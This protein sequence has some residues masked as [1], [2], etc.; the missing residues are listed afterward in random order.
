MGFRPAIS[1]LFCGA[2][3]TACHDDEPTPAASARAEGTPGVVAP[4]REPE[5]LSLLDLLDTCEVSHRGLSIDLGSVAAETQ[6]SFGQAFN[7]DVTPVR[8]GGGTF[9]ELSERAVDYQFWLTDPLDALYVSV[10]VRGRRAG[11]LAVYV[12]GKRL[13]SA[14]LEQNEARVANFKLSHAELAP[15][16]H[17]LGLRL[18]RGDRG[19]EGPYAEVEWIRLTSPDAADDQY[20]APTFKDMISDVVLQKRPRRS[21]ALRDHS[22]V[23]CPIWPAADTRL[24]LWLGFWGKGSGRAEVRV[25]RQ[26]GEA[27]TLEQREIEGGDEATWTPVDLALGR[28]AGELVALEFG[29]RQATGTGRVAFGDPELLR[30][31]SASDAVNANTVVLVVMAGLRRA[32][33]PPWGSLPSLPGFGELVRVGTAFT[34]YRAPSTVPAAA[35]AS[36]LTGVSPRGHSVED[37]S[38]RLPKAVHTINEALK[39]ASGHAAMFTG[40]P[41]SFPAFGFD[42][43]WD[44][45]E[46][47]SPVSDEPAHAPFQ[48]AEAWLKRNFERVPEARRFVLI[49]SRGAHP[50]WDVT[51]EEAAQ[52]KPEEYDGPVDA[53]RG[54]IALG[55]LRASHRRASRRLGTDD[56]TRLRALELAALKKQDAAFSHLVRTL[57]QLNLWEASLVMVVGDVAAGEPPQVPYYPAGDLE[58]SR[59][60]VP[61]LVKFPER[62][63]AGK[64]VGVPVTAVDLAATILAAFGL[65]APPGAEGLDLYELA[66]GRLPLAGRPLVATLGPAFATRLG[67][68]RLSGQLGETPRL[69]ELAVDPAC[70]NNVFEERGFVASSLWKWTYLTERE[71]RLRASV[72]REPASIDPETSAA[73]AVWGDLQ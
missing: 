14:R 66:R 72:T 55:N 23:R 27:V 37:Q 34:N 56:W 53:R 41:T 63:L 13:G 21:I 15:G 54:G 4:R 70:V 17:S 9:A 52:M 5:T 59:L 65:E 62:H 46:T 31:K 22:V 47:I 18:S 36:M 45:Q 38:A 50:P 44:E 30:N 2:V 42:R 8:L 20:A 3:L 29:V 7:K 60:F 33:L 64:E 35:L 12:D 24:K 19:S 43:A 16:R 39:Q 1:L 11:H 61:L 25:V 26:G 40:A 28:Y 48:Q 49:H 6:R 69:C 58:E 71:A 68:W 10:R 32:S 57:Q 67:P 73:L 51:K